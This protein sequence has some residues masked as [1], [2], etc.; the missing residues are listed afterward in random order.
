MYIYVNFFYGTKKITTKKL[1]RLG[2]FSR[3]R[4]YKKNIL[5]LETKE[6]VS[7]KNKYTVEKI[8]GALKN[9]ETLS[10][11]PKVYEFLSKNEAKSTGKLLHV[12]ADVDSTVTHTGVSTLNRNVSSFIE[13]LKKHKGVFYFCTG[14]SYQ[15]VEHL[16]KL[17]DTGP[18]GIAESGGY[19]VG[20]PRD[21]RF[22]GKKTEPKKL[23][24]YM[25]D[26][27]INFDFDSN[28]HPH[29]TEFVIL[30]DSIK[31]KTLQR[32]IKNSHADV[33]YHASKTTYHISKSGKNKGTAVEFL[34]SP[35]ELGL[36]SEMEEVIAIGDSDLDYPMLQ[37]ADR[38]FI[39][40]KPNGELATKI[41]K[42]GR[43]ITRLSL[44]PKALDELYEK[45]F[46]YG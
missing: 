23:I 19:V 24:K 16:R 34:T 9:I 13:K 21:E 29:L 15:D 27:E 2:L 38:G 36:D 35:E 22:W 26:N 3:I 6:S 43:K 28:Q 32:A 37:Y 1:Q 7:K 17:Y 18:Y 39:V 42:L 10:G 25:I 31:E 44:P 5:K 41:A 45:L 40:G 33:E 46:P 8:L 12:F 14:R 4:L 20:I 30:K 11:E